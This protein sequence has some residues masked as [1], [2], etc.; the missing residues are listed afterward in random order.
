M[1][2]EPI[3]QGKILNLVKLEQRWEVVE[4]AP[5]VCIL[6]LNE[7]QVLGVRQPRPAIECHTWELP[8]GLIDPGESPHDAALRELAEETQ[9]SGTLSLITQVYTS[10]GFCTEKLYLFEA[11]ELR[12]ASGKPD[13]GEDV[14]AEWRDL[15]S[16]WR[17]LQRGELATSAPTALGLSVALA[18][19]GLVP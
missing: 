2:R 13:E 7:Q 5:A 16:S 6:A 19:L 9:L 8:A 10:P 4:H 17:A 11:R 18:R 1:T 14:T 15:L 12:P 3:Y